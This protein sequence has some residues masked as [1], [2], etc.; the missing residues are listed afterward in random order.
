MAITNFDRV[1]VDDLRVGEHGQIWSDAVVQLTNAQLLALRATPQTVIAAPGA[2]KAVIVDE[3]YMH[4]DVTTTGY[5]ESAANV[6]VEYSGGTDIVVVEATGFVDQATDQ[7]RL[8]VPDY[9]TIFTPVANE[10]VQLKNNGAGEWTG[11][12]AANTL[13]VRIKYHIV[14]TAAFS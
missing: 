2:G 12:N 11:G 9:T 14:D 8:Q 1:D 3:V 5:T 6:A 10:A 4:L 13:S 7:S